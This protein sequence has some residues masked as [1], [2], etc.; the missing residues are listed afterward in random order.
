MVSRILAAVKLTR[1]CLFSAI[2]FSPDV[3]RQSRDLAHEGAIIRGGQVDQCYLTAL[4][5][6]AAAAY[7][8]RH[9]DQRREYRTCGPVAI[10]RGISAV[11]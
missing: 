2:V 11:N 5:D 9:D 6:G 4:T 7:G 1:P 8:T 10:R 3:S